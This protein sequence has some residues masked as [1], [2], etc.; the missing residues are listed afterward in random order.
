MEDEAHVE[1]EEEFKLDRQHE[2]ALDARKG[3]VEELVKVFQ[4]V[5]LDNVAGHVLNQDKF[6]QLSDKQAHNKSR[7][8]NGDRCCVATA[9]MRLKR[10]HS[11]FWPRSQFDLAA[12]MRLELN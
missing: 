6:S 4:E 9:V 5:H 11:W 1:N 7:N 2:N 3:Q 12:K 10:K 8:P